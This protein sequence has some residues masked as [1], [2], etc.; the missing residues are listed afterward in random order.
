MFVKYPMSGTID[1]DLHRAFVATRFTVELTG[2]VDDIRIGERLP[3]ALERYLA[4]VGETDWA[5]VTAWNPDSVPL[6]VEE[7]RVRQ[8]ALR[9]ELAPRHSLLFGVGIGNDGWSEESIFAAGIDVDE[10]AKIGHAHGQLCVVAGTSGDVARLVYCD[11]G[12]A[13]PSE[14]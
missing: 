5:Y 6:P 1:P 10:V 2:V 13:C 8:D 11:S 4:Q 12:A 9:R 14:S 3:A 7:N